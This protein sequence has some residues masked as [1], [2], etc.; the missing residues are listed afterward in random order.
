MAYVHIGVGGI[1]RHLCV[2]NI[3]RLLHILHPLYSG[4]KINIIYFTLIIQ[5]AQGTYVCVLEGIDVG[6]MWSDVVDETRE[7]GENCMGDHCP[8]TCLDSDSKPD[9]RV[10]YP[11]RCPAPWPYGKKRNNLPEHAERKESLGID[12]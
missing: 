5:K 12:F 11:L 9:R 3:V 7:P 1:P 4:K 6:V 8:A 10:R 2:L